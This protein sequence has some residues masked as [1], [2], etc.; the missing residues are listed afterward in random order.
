MKPSQKTKLFGMVI[1][2]IKMEISL[3]QL[4]KNNVTMQASSREQRDYH[5]GNNK[6]N[7]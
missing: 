3:P 1:D 4:C 6:V 5:H 2:S 7:M